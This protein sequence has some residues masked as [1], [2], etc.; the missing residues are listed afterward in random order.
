MNITEK[1][2]ELFN[3]ELT[4]ENVD[5][6]STQPINKVDGLFRDITSW[7]AHYEINSQLEDRAMTCIYLKGFEIFKEK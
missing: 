1:F 3:L 5:K 2:R 7:K 6:I 4:K